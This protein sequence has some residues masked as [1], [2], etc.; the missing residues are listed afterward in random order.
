MNK[1]LVLFSLL[2]LISCG[3]KSNVQNSICKNLY[4]NDKFELCLPSENWNVEKIENYLVFKD[5]SEIDK[6]TLLIMID[7]YQ[8]ELRAENLRNRH[9]K[10]M[11][12]S[13]SLNAKLI[14]K[15]K[16]QIDGKTFY[17][18]E[19]ITKSGK[20]YSYFLF[21]NK[22]DI[23]YLLSASIDEKIRGEINKNDYLNIFKSFN[24]K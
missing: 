24:I 21:Y 7:N 19:V 11:I 1:I 10:K 14:S 18:F 22:G 2:F 6:S 12:E 16:E 5:S 4:E 13:K 23:G 8:S 9:L 17:D 3:N 15:G 20:I